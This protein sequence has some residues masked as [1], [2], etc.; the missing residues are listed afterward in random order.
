[1]QYLTAETYGQKLVSV[2]DEQYQNY[3]D[4]CQRTVDDPLAWYQSALEHEAN[5]PARK[6]R[7]AKL[8]K[9]KA[10]LDSDASGG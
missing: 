1:M 4:A 10:A 5:G 2:P 7:I 3:L 9:A 6:E 8:N